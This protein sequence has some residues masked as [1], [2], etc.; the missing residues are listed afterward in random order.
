MNERIVLNLD[1]SNDVRFDVKITSSDHLGGTSGPG[2]QLRLVCETNDLEYSFRGTSTNDGSVQIIV[3][4]MKGVMTEGAYDAR[5]EVIVEGRYFVPLEFTAEFKV[6][7]KV[8]AEGVRVIGKTKQ[9]DTSVNVIAA[10]KTAERVRPQHEVRV[11]KK[12]PSIDDMDVLL[13]ELT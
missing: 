7:L 11:S 10:V 6:P 13:R 9:V 3:P 8:V 4:P 12:Q 2:V 1:E 5:L